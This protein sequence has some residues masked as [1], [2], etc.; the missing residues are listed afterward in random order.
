VGDDGVIDPTTQLWTPETQYT[1]SYSEQTMADNGY[2]EWDKVV[3]LDTGNQVANQNN[4]EATTQFDFVS[5]ED[6]FGRATFSESLLLD[7][8]SQGSSAGDSMMCPFSTGDNGFIPA[9]CNVVEMGSSFTGSSVSMITRANERHVSSSA[10]VP[11]GMQYS[12]SLSG[13]GSAAAWINA[14]IMEGRTGNVFDR[15]LNGGITY[16]DMFY[17]PDT[18]DMSP[19]NGFMQGGDLVYKEKTTASG[20]IESFSKSMSYQSGMRRI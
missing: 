10:D 17:N 19:A 11:V 13:V 20:I 18:G 16:D 7:A 2:T 6:A 8:A 14:H 5:F 1:M 3:S 12:V 4:F 9:Y 15:G